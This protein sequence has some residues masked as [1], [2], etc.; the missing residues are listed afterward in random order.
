MGQCAVS[1]LKNLMIAKLNKLLSKVSQRNTFMFF[2]QVVHFVKKKTKLDGF[3]VVL[4]QF[5]DFWGLT[6]SKQMHLIFLPEIRGNMEFVV[7]K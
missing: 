4:C 5:L 7:G 6:G 3:M 2:A 1:V